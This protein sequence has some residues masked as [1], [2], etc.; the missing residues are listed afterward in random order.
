M[1]NKKLTGIPE[2]SVPTYRNEKQ[3]RKLEVRR[4][5]YDSARAV[6]LARWR[7]RLAIG[8]EGTPSPAQ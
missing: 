2:K 8:G 4:Q 3:E 7:R 1:A 5:A 6:R